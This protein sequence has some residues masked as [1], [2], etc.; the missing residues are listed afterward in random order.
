MCIIVRHVTKC[1]EVFHTFAIISKHY[2]IDNNLVFQ[3]DEETETRDVLNRM[4]MAIREH[5]FAIKDLKE[6]LRLKNEI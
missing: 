2:F 1:N 6:Q 5:E 4:R 3:K